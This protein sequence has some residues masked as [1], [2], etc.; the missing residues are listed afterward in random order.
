MIARLPYPPL[1]S[2]GAA[3]A[4]FFCC[5][6]LA[7]F[8]AVRIRT[9][10]Q[11]DYAA[12]IFGVVSRMVGEEGLPSLFSSVPVWFVKEIPYNVFKFLVFQI[13]SDFLYESFPAARE[14]IRLSLLVSLR[15]FYIS[16]PS[17]FVRS[18]LLYARARP[19]NFH[20]HLNPTLRDFFM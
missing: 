2:T 16:F 18:C 4:G 5:F 3:T 9:V 14:D 19:G 10:S 8:D 12:N 6:I 20:L 1:P 17:F 13:A 15:E 7:P 11:P